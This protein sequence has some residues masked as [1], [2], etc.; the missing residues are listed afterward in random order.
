MAAGLRWFSQKLLSTR[1]LLLVTPILVVALVAAHL[2]TAHEEAQIDRDS[3]SIATE[4]SPSIPKLTEIATTIRDIT[5]LVTLAVDGKMDGA[6]ARATFKTYDDFL[7]RKQ[8]EYLRLPS[9][10]GAQILWLELDHSIDELTRTADRAIDHVEHGD[11]ELARAAVAEQMAPRRLRAGNAI[12]LLID[13]NAGEAMRLSE[14]IHALRRRVGLE[15]YALE[16][17]VALLALIVGGLAWRSLR[18][19]ARI[20]EERRQ[21]AETRAQEME[22]FAGRVA[23]DLKSPLGAMLFRVGL[24]ARHSG[25]ETFGRLSQQIQSMARLIDGLLEFA[26]SGAQPEPGARAP[27]DEVLRDVAASLREDAVRSGVALELPGASGLSVSCN[28]GALVS[29]L[30]NLVSNAI[31]F[32][33]ERPER[34]V[35]VRALERGGRVR[36]EVDD[37]GPGVPAGQERAVFEPYVRL[38]ETQRLPG[39]GLGL[40]TVRRIIE[41]YGGEVGVTSRPGEGACFWFELPPAQPASEEARAVAASAPWVH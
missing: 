27:L 22:L 11:M 25:D 6:A 33:G 21:L 38:P 13:M 3:E 29:V 34:R 28:A 15:A 30:R 36:V 31:K 5:A 26:L 12:T 8:A 18:A 14:E 23:H 37:T 4:T 19:Q 7:H 9:Y 35:T 10:G 1:L 2:V 40:A 17:M 24:A 16:G 41:A 32:V 20:A 39:L